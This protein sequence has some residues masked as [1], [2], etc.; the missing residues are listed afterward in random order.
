M[1][2]MRFQASPTACWITQL[3]PFTPQQRGLLSFISELVILKKN[4]YDGLVAFKG[5][6]KSLSV[7]KT[8]A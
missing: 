7:L 4:L 2:L 3:P 6:G 8:A 1:A 5:S